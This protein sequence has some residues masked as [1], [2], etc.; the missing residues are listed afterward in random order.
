[1]TMSMTMTMMMIKLVIMMMMMM[2][3]MINIVMIILIMMTNQ[4]VWPYDS[5]VCFL[6]LTKNWFEK[7]YDTYLENKEI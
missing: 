6:Y 7:H 5:S 4:M 2:I 3:M 1:M